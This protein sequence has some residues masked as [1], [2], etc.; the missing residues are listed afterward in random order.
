MGTFATVLGF[1]RLAR[2]ATPVAGGAMPARGAGAAAHGLCAGNPAHAGLRR[3]RRGR[4]IRTGT[5]VWRGYK[6]NGPAREPEIPSKNPPDTS[7]LVRGVGQR[8]RAP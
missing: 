5:R 3:T 6:V 4:A 8:R 7:V 2:V 1:G